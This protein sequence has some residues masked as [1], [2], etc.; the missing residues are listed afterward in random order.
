MG[1]KQWANGRRRQGEHETVKR[2]TALPV[3]QDPSSPPATLCHTSCGWKKWGG[4]RG[5]RGGGLEMGY[6]RRQSEARRRL[7]KGGGQVK[8]VSA[9][10][11]KTEA[12]RRAGARRADRRDRRC[13]RGSET[14]LWQRRAPS[15]SSPSTEGVGE[16]GETRQVPTAARGAALAPASADERSESSRFPG[17]LTHWLAMVLSRSSFQEAAEREAG[18]ETPNAPQALTALRNQSVK[19]APH[20]TPP[21]TPA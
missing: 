1:S 20:P 15:S 11:S 4:G 13:Q 2:Q 18:L 8:K 3:P 10:G 16:R 9:V 14:L 6:A 12:W 7:A 21:S 5:E 19:T 17:G